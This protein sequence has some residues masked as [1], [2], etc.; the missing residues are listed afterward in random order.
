MAYSSGTVAASPTPAEDFVAAGG[1]LDTAL[2][3]AGFSFVEAAPNY[4]NFRTRVYKSAQ[5]DNGVTDWYLIVT[6]QTAGP[7]VAL[8]VAEGYNTATHMPSA[9][10]FA[11]TNTG[12]AV[13]LNADGTRN[14]VY[15]TSWPGTAMSNGAALL[16]VSGNGFS[17]WLSVNPERVV[18]ATRNATTDNAGYAGLFDDWLGGGLQP[19]PLIVGSPGSSSGTSGQGGGTTRQPGVTVAGSVPGALS[20]Y[21][22]LSAYVPTRDYAH[23]ITGKYTAYPLTV[24][25]GRRVSG[26]IL[27]ALKDVVQLN[28]TAVNGDTLTYQGKTYVNMRGNND[29]FVDTTV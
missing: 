8:T 29:C 18:M 2:L 7:T 17:W 19:K 6:V 28:V 1:V 24:H 11:P 20:R 21:M 22:A 9:M 5:A 3:A 12:T 16:T 15:D 4:S 10:A 23:L 25:D 13:V 26:S 27:G 14:T